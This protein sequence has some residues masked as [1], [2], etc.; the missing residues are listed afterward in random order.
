[1]TPRVC[2]R[3]AHLPACAYTSCAAPHV[4][5]PLLGCRW[6]CGALCPDARVPFVLW[7]VCTPNTLSCHPCSFSHL[8]L[9]PICNAHHHYSGDDSEGLEKLRLRRAR[10]TV[11]RGRPM[12]Y[13]CRVGARIP[14][15]PGLGWSNRAKLMQHAEVV[16]AQDTFIVRQVL[17]SR[18]KIRQLID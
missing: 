17:S 11:G 9:H 18:F 10:V 3:I 16:R 5:H 13:Q 1:M 12:V 4:A 2:E 7:V 6:H 15:W 14:A 8:A